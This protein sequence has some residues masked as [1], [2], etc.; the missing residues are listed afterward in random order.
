MTGPFRSVIATIAATLALTGA[1]QAQ[2]R[3]NGMVE[4]RVPG[5]LTEEQLAG[6]A[7][8]EQTCANCH[9]TAG[10]GRMGY[11]P[12]LIHKI[13]ES[14]HHGDKAFVIAIRQGVRAHHWKFGN[15]P[16]QPKISEEDA[17]KI[18][19]YVRAV[20]KNNGID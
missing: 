3:V 7:L 19:A 6:K 1:A 9:G 20:Q 5:M 18:I 13:Y 10:S 4:V 14:A 8:F 12:P 11:G 2:D 16:P 17:R 15:M